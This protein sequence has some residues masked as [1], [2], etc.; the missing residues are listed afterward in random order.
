M[1]FGEEEDSS[2]MASK[3]GFLKNSMVWHQKEVSFCLSSQPCL[4]W[5]TV[6]VFPAIL[7]NI[8]TIRRIKIE[9][10]VRVM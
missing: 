5:L 4:S 6:L 7:T 10:S 3:R 9:F 1:N 2:G 8:F